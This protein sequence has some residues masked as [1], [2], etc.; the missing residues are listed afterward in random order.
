E[1]R[2]QT[3]FARK[4]GSVA[5]PTAGLH[6]TPELIDDLQAE[7]LELTLHVGAGTFKPVSEDSIQ[8]HIMHEEE[9]LVSLETI[10]A[11]MS[12][13]PRFAV[14]TTSLRTLES[15]FWM[16]VKWHNS[17]QLPHAINQFD[18][19]QERNP[20]ASYAAAMEF[21]GNKM[22]SD[23][24]SQLRFQTSIMISPGYEIRSIDGLF[25]NFHMPKSTLLFLV[26]A[27]VGNDWKNI[28][29]HALQNDYRFL[30]YGDSSLLM[31]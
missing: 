7:I 11:L 12:H 9:C 13:K 28:Y 19:Y 29:N 25:T 18:P 22:K 4:K 2:Y 3:T 5:A 31:R 20:F 21:L 24:L 15:L 23:G 26:A 16:A 30:S 10:N 6:F 14:G 27:W 1:E 17:Q 8:Q